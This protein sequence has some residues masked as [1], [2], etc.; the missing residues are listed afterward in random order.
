M[1][2]LN[3]AAG[4]WKNLLLL[5][6]PE[7]NSPATSKD[8]IASA[9]KNLAQALDAFQAGNTYN[10]ATRNHA[11]VL[12]TFA[13]D[14]HFDLYSRARLT[15]F[16]IACA[17]INIKWYGDVNKFLPFLVTIETIVI[18]IYLEYGTI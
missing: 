5:K 13:S 7:K 14:I 11:P 17:L 8:S 9:L 18:Y 10:G 6:L 16:Q 1:F 2:K 3:A 15:E 4:W 12:D